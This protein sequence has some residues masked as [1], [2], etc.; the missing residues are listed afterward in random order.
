MIAASP[1]IVGQILPVPSL[2]PAMDVDDFPRK[3]I[4]TDFQE[5]PLCIHTDCAGFR[6]D[7]DRFTLAEC[8][9]NSIGL[10]RNSCSA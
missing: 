9:F 4:P 5:S 8:H 1:Q 10:R 6:T 2:F 3:G 7:V